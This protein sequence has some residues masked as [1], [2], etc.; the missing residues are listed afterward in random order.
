[1]YLTE[2]QLGVCG[3]SGAVVFGGLKDGGYMWR[4]TLEGDFPVSKEMEKVELGRI[5]MRGYWEEEG[6]ILRSKG[7]K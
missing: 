2:L 5:C 3:E 7:T 1:M 4:V 6:V